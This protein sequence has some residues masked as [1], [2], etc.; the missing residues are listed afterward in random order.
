MYPPNKRIAV[1][2]SDGTIWAEKP[3]PFQGYF[4][5]ERL[6]NISTTDSNLKQN[7]NNNNKP[8]CT[9]KCANK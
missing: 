5:L 1:F 8:I 9:F 7:C 4:A 2:D 6:E 3:I